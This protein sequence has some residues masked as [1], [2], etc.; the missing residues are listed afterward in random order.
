V[1]DL[2]PPQKTTKNPTKKLQ[3]SPK[4]T[5]KKTKNSH[6]IT[7]K[8]TNNHNTKQHY[9]K[10]KK[11]KQPTSKI[12]PTKHLQKTTHKILQKYYK[13]KSKTTKYPTIS[14]QN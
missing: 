4:S 11:T 12:S 3:N 2:L 7:T 6:H 8:K 13:T 1:Q 5:S 10:I 9:K 14:I